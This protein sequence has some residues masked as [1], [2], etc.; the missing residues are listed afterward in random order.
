MR[1]G[2][3]LVELSIVL[4]IIGLLLGG[5]LKGKAMIENAKIK[6]VKSDVDSIVA[7]VYSYQDRFNYL[8]GDDRNDRTADLGATGCTGGN[9]DGLFNQGAIEYACAWQELVGAGFISGDPTDND[10]AT[11]PKRTPF[12]GRYL[13]RYRNNYNGKSGNYIYIENIPTNVIKALDEKYDDGQYDAGDLQSP[14]D[15]NSENNA[16][17]DVYWFAF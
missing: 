9:G 5:V 15:Y 4:V 1:K 11:V 14:T 13:F 7:A 17:A 10:E 12:G 6:R 16:Y 8:P 2:F 3:T